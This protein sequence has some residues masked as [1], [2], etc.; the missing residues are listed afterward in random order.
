MSLCLGGELVPCIAAGMV[1]GR[2]RQ[3]SLKKTLNLIPLF[4]RVFRFTA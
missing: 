2:M 1:S 3:P 4:P